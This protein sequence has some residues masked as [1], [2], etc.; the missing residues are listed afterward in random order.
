MHTCLLQQQGSMAWH[1]EHGAVKFKKPSLHCFFLGGGCKSGFAAAISWI[2]G[3]LEKQ[4]GFFGGGD[5]WRVLCS[6]AQRVHGRQQRRAGMGAKLRA[7]FSPE[8]VHS[9]MGFNI[10]PLQPQPDASLL[11]DG[12]PNR[13]Q[14]P[15]SFGAGFFPASL[16]AWTGFILAH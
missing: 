10:A 3:N 8:M 15:R 7:V 16:L 1:I 5:C 12:D 14:Q 11:T 4:R 6:T 9:K 13:C 2:Q